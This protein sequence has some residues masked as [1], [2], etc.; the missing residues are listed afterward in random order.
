VRGEGAVLLDWYYYI[1]WGTLIR[2][3]RGLCEVCRGRAASTERLVLQIH[4]SRPPNQH[5]TQPRKG[6]A[7]TYNGSRGSSLGAMSSRGGLGGGLLVSGGDCT[8][9]IPKPVAAEYFS[10]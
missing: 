5:G 6:I 8:R 2:L 9:L 10:S 1:S 3:E 4:L 7:S